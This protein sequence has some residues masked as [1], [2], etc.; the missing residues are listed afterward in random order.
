VTD[1]RHP[2]LV[3]GAI[4]AD[5]TTAAVPRAF[6]VF[7]TLLAEDGLRWF[8]DRH[9]ARLAAACRHF[10]IPAFERLDVAAEVARYHARLGA[11]PMLIRTTLRRDPGS[12]ATSIVV[13]ARAPRVVPAEG[14]ELLLV[15]AE[16]DPLGA[17]KTTRRLARV[18]AGEQAEAA[19]GFDALLVLPGGEVVEA[20]RGNLFALV[21]GR[22]R[23]PPLAA[24]CL[25]GVVRGL[26]LES[27]E[28][29][30]EE[31]LALDDLR[32]A[33]EVWLTSSGVRVAPVRAIR[34]LRGDLP[35]PAGAGAL[36]AARALRACEAAYRAR[37]AAT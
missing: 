15:P 10:A 23:T 32:R 27:L 17:W 37:T 3:D 2:I 4:H 6:G 5:A 34:G 8:E 16:P 30:V 18:L 11:G 20:A 14:A 31:R 9:L 33:S 26:L 28:G 1:A 36:A 12:G 35:G 25:P 19:G 24:G 22:V 21:D 13:D 29:A 7:D